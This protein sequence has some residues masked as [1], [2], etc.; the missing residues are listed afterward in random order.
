VGHIRVLE[1][2]PDS[3]AWERLGQNLNGVGANNCF[4]SSLSLSADGRTVA[5]GGIGN[6]AGGLNAG[7]VVRVFDFNQDSG[8][9]EQIGQDLNGVAE[10]NFFGTSVALS[11]DGRTVASGASTNNDG[12]DSGG[13]V[14]VFVG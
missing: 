11:A 10:N 3:G 8:V 9:W 1:F 13:H 6:D 2:N 5:G 7:H 4:G 14:R 12:A